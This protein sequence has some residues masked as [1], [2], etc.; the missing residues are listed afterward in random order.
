MATKFG[1][2]PRNNESLIVNYPPNQTIAT[3]DQIRRS[4]ALQLQMIV[5]N[6]EHSLLISC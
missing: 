3:E 1:E 4:V 5:W 6:P 2:P